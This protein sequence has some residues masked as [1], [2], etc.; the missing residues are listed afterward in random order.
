MGADHSKNADSVVASTLVRH[1]G[2]PALHA[3]ADSSL[4]SESQELFCDPYDPWPALDFFFRELY[5]QSQRVGD[6][7]RQVC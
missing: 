7:V 2:S 5:F 1:V 4:V 6:A 3:E